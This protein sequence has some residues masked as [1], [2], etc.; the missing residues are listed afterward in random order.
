MRS[1]IDSIFIS[2]P[3]IHDNKLERN[4]SMRYDRS[5]PCRA[6]GDKCDDLHNRSCAH[7]HVSASQ[8]AQKHD[9]GHLVWILFLTT[10]FIYSRVVRQ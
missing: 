4:R 1:V 9:V 7:E 6:T 3:L 10:S 2:N 8:T 5:G